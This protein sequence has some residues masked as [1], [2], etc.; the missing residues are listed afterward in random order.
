MGDDTYEI[1]LDLSLP[2]VP[3]CPIVDCT[4]LSRASWV[5]MEVVFL[6][7]SIL[8]VVEGIFCD[9]HTQDCIDENQLGTEDVGFV[10]LE[11]LIHSKVEPTIGSHSKSG[12]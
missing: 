6:N 7:D 9:T 8:A 11:S 10:I 5:Y 1:H 3:L 12:H 2:Y 4:R